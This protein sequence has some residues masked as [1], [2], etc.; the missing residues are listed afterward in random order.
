MRT[1]DMCLCL[2]GCLPAC[3]PSSQHACDDSGSD[4]ELDD[5]EEG[6]HEGD[7]RHITITQSLE[8]QKNVRLCGPCDLL[9]EMPETSAVGLTSRAQELC[10]QCQ[11]SWRDVLQG[12]PMLQHG[13]PK[14]PHSYGS[15]NWGISKVRIPLTS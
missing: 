4:G 9:L 3:L 13:Y 11:N 7:R 2:A 8:S 14:H 15:P 5:A 12:A 6:Q 1:Y 10:S